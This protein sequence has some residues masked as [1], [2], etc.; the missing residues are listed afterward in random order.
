[1]KF[2]QPQHHSLSLSLPCTS[3]VGA[4]IFDESS[5]IRKCILVGGFGFFHFDG[6]RWNKSQAAAEQPLHISQHPVKTIVQ[7]REAGGELSG[8]PRVIQVNRPLVPEEDTP[9]F[10]SNYVSTTKYTFFNFLPIALFEQFNRVANFY[11]LVAAG[12]TFT[13]YAPFDWPSQVVPLALVVGFSLAKE[14]Y[15]DLQRYWQDK[16]A[17]RRDTAVHVGNGVF[18]KKQW[19]EVCV[20]DIVNVKKR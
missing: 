6:K 13:D 4:S 14:L 16:A 2:S 11:F 12:L 20:G 1:M 18:E 5:I 9:T 17:N 8:Y 19:R 10:C 7:E 15:E 3:V